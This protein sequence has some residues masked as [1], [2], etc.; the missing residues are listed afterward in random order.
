MQHSYT[1]AD[2]SHPPSGDDLN[3][4]ARNGWRVLQILVIETSP[5]ATWRVYFERK[6]A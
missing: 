6:T 4:Y 1:H 5:S 2:Y 3:A